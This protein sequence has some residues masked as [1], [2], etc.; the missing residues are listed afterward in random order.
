[1]LGTAAMVRGALIGRLPRKSVRS[2][3]VMSNGNSRD[4]RPKGPGTP[5]GG[6]GQQ[7][8]FKR[9][10]ATIDLKATEITAVDPKS[11]AGQ[12]TATKVEPGKPVSSAPE[13]P[14]Q[15]VDAARTLATAAAT[16]AAAQEAL[17]QPK[18]NASS[19][20]M[21]AGTVPPIQVTST[22]Q[23]AAAKIQPGDAGKVTPRGEEKP[24]D[25]KLT[26]TKPT[27]IKP[28][29]T[30]TP[31]TKP[32]GGF[33][34][35][36]AAGIMGGA[37][38]LGGAYALG[39]QS[40]LLSNS[41]RPGDQ[42]V[43]RRLAALEKSTPGQ[44][45][46]N[47]AL[48][49]RLER[50]EQAARTLTEA[51]TQVATAARA[52]DDKATA[53]AQDRVQKLEEQI[54]TMVAAATADPQRAGRLPQLA[55]I[56]TKLAEIEAALQSRQVQ[57]KREIAADVDQKLE[58]DLGQLKGDTATTGGR[59]QALEASVKRLLEEAGAM[60]ASIDTLRSDLGGRAKPQDVVTALE[61]LTQKMTTLERSVQTV[62]R[63]EQERNTNAERIVLS[64]EL[65]NLKRALDR[66]QKYAPELAAIRKLAGDKLDLTALEK[67]AATGVP[68]TDGM[69]AD[70]RVLAFKVIDADS[71][72]QDASVMDR[73]MAGAKSMVRVR[74]TNPSPD[75]KGTEATLARMEAALKDG[76][77]AQVIEE[78]APLSDKAKA[79]LGPWLQRIEARAT[80]DRAVGKLEADLKSAL[81]SGSAATA[82]PK[83]VN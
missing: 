27:D 5:S 54:A 3:D 62:V 50:I 11:A 32:R 74:K 73:M 72:P 23:A 16:V 82:P 46:A 39:P 13:R 9:P 8:I 7:P 31:E 4:D 24:T 81:T 10:Q 33:A 21:S 18:I 17:S 45:I 28:M 19:A 2:V 15:P 49:Q 36:L 77:V 42:D 44:P 66:G 43:A 30:S 29:A 40:G 58:R 35:H 22:N 79:A 63:S 6:S 41:Q 55:Q 57:L 78:S 37:L 25:V 38:T 51:Q 80:I 61:P 59:A 1:M 34:S 20:P 47:P 71:Q 75:D 53:L 65:G 83:G 26:G 67:F 52:A 64:L 48:D 76:R 70:F 14:V 68:T 12:T 60:R 56:T 69:I